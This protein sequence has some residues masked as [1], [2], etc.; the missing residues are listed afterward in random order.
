MRRIALVERTRQRLL[1]RVGVEHCDAPDSLVADAHVHDAPCAEVGERHPGD[2]R[3][4]RLIVERL[5]EAPADVRQEREAVAAR[6]RG[7]ALALGDPARRAVTLD[8]PGG[9]R[10]LL[11]A[12]AVGVAYQVV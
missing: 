4:S 8:G 10:L 2:G 12:T 9:C 1:G 6:L 3:E 5:S 7:V 11:L